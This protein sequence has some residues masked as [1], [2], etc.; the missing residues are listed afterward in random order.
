MIPG[1]H[2]GRCCVGN[3]PLVLP[4]ATLPSTAAEWERHLWAA[5]MCATIYIPTSMEP[6]HPRWN[7]ARM[8]STP[9]TSPQR[10]YPSRYRTYSMYLDWLLHLPARKRVRAAVLYHNMQQKVWRG[11]WWCF[12]YTSLR[13]LSLCPSSSSFSFSSSS[14]YSSSSYLHSYLPRGV[15][16]V[17]AES[18]A[19]DGLSWM[20]G[21]N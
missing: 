14:S 15:R 10:Q 18:V 7:S 11:H 8:Q 20:R 2:L 19:C 3:S 4:P 17:L 13:L 12:A 21:G 6:A 9:H 1:I 16:P 5:A